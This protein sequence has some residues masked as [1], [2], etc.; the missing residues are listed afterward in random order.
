MTVVVGV[1]GALVGAGDADADAGLEQAVDDVVV[2]VGR[3]R[4]NPP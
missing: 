2:R 4:K 1:S 3:S